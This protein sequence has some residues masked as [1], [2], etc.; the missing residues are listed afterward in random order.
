LAGRACGWRI[1]GGARLAGE[2]EVEG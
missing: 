2:V 1:V